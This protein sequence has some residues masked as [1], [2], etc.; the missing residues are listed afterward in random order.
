MKIIIKTRFPILLIVM[1]L[2]SCG[3]VTP[4]PT[5]LA[6]ASVSPTSILLLST[7]VPPVP[8]SK[9]V[10][11]PKANEQ[12]YIDPDGWYTIS[13]PAD[14]TVAEKPNAFSG[15]DGA[16]ETGYLPEMGYLSNRMNVCTQ[17]AN[18][19]K[20][21]N[22]DKFWLPPGASNIMWDESSCSVSSDTK[23]YVI[24]ENPSADPAHRYIYIKTNSAS[25]GVTF[26]WLAPAPKP[27]T[28]LTPSSAANASFWENAG[29]MPSNISVTE[30]DYHQ[31]GGPANDG[32]LLRIVRAH[33]WPIAKFTT[34]TP[35]AVTIKKLG[36]ELRTREGQLS[37]LYRDGRPFLDR[38]SEVSDV[39]T[40]ST[41]SGP[42]TAF[43]AIVGPKAYYNK[44]VVIQN[45]M[46]TAIWDNSAFDIELAPVLY[47]GELLWAKAGPGVHINIRK[48][49]GTV[50]YTFATYFGASLPKHQ[51]RGWKGHWILNVGEFLVQD[52]E[53]I[54]Q[55][56]GFD[57]IF[58]W[59]LV[60]DKPIFFF[61]KGAKIG[62]SYDGHV[63]P[64]QYDDVAH[65]LCCSLTVNNPWIG[66]DV[67]NFFGKRDGVWYYVAMELK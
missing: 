57:E 26:S 49:D 42:V 21:V 28:D 41:A 27:E 34:A 7:P 15:P 2:V 33:G 18:F 16:L 11:P 14:M 58:D 36:Y 40:F 38:V 3:S 37:Q 6:T 48:S 25:I 43:I 66:D 52:G 1:L 24:Y 55:K 67:V 60:K 22:L 63:L 51:F 62:V 45:D 29:P 31:A 56:L 20:A 5:P 39:Y 9:T 53:N 46:I 4:F 32:D 50:V 47:R 65:G 54:N 13:F 23:K 30:Y 35:P 64:L 44:D 61:R 59:G 12:V 17:L 19:S 10:I 8:V